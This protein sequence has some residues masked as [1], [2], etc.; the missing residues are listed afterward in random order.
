MVRYLNG[1]KTPKAK[2]NSA[3]GKK[4]KYAKKN[5]L[6]LGGFVPQTPQAGSHR[7][8]VLDKFS[9]IFVNAA[10]LDRRGTVHGY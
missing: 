1:G 7:R 8:H 5:K 3:R 4:N 2:K 9:Y 10:I 6:W